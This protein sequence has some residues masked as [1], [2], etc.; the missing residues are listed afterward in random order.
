MKLFNPIPAARRGLAVGGVAVTA[1]TVVSTAAVAGIPPLT[2]T[3]DPFHLA[4]AEVWEKVSSDYE[5]ALHFGG[6][7]WPVWVIRRGHPVPTAGEVADRWLKMV[8]ADS[9]VAKLLGL[10]RMDW[11]A[12]IKAH[13]MTREFIDEKVDDA[14]DA[15][16]D[17]REKIV[18]EVT[19]ETLL[20][21]TMPPGRGRDIH[22]KTMRDSIRHEA[23]RPAEIARAAG[24]RLAAGEKDVTR[25]SVGVYRPL[26]TDP[27]YERTSEDD[28]RSQGKQWERPLPDVPNQPHPKGFDTKGADK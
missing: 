17:T 4:S 7:S 26:W 9:T 3:S 22:I 27:A 20:I 25:N 19:E 14:G 11:R 12:R 13:G 15:Y 6:T 21:G 5:I 24:W 28:W 10:D 2:P 23:E 8:P 16:H 18:Q 1:A